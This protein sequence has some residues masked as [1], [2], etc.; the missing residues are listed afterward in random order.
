[1][2]QVNDGGVEQFAGVINDGAF[3]AVAVAGVEAQGGQAAGGRG[4]QQVF[5]VAREDG[6]GVVVGGF[7]E[8]IQRVQLQREVDFGAP[9]EADGVAQPFVFADAVVRGDGLFV[10]A[11]FGRGR[12]VRLVFEGELQHAFVAPAQ[13][14]K[15]A[16]ARHGADGFAVVKVVFVF[17]AFGFF[18]FDDLRVQ[19]AFRPQFFAQ[20]A[21]EFGVFGELFHQDGARAVQRR[22]GIG[23]VFVEVRRGGSVHVLRLFGQ[24]QVGERLQAVFARDL[25]LGAAFGF[26]GEVEV[27]QRGFVVGGVNGGAQLVGEFAL[28]FDAV[29]YGLLARGQFAQVLQALGEQTQLAVVQPAGRFFAVAGDKRHGRAVVQKVDGGGDLCGGGGEFGGEEGGDVHRSSWL[30]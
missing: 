22:F 1:M 25:C 17:F 29:Q 11:G 2:V 13:H 21:D 23:D 19:L 20:C 30:W 7:F 27:F 5:E 9:G 28:F 6:D 12:F 15:R 16:V 3:D 10:G 8:A 26:V 18:A 4:K 24:Q 14:G